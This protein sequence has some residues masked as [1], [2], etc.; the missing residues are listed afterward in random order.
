MDLKFVPF[1]LAFLVS[2][3][4]AS[5]PASAQSC[6]A[7]YFV[8]GGPGAY[9]CAPIPVSGSGSDGSDV[10][11]SVTNIR[12]PNG[13]FSHAV[14]VWHPDVANVWVDG[15]FVFNASSSDS[16]KEADR[17]KGTRALAECN[18]MMGSGCVVAWEWW[19]SEIVVF[20]HRD[21]TFSMSP[22]SDYQRAQ[23]ECS[24]TQVLEC[25]GFKVHASETRLLNDTAR[26]YYAVAAWVVG[27]VTDNNLYVATGH[28]SWGDANA[29]A[30]KACNDATS[31]KCEIATWNSS[32]Y[33]QA[34][35]MGNS[36]AHSFSFGAT[37]ETTAE[38]AKEAAQALC[39]EH[40]N[41]ICELQVTFDSKKPGLFVHDFNKAWPQ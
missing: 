18:K 16:D 20:H 34:Y 27:S 8:F 25:A 4:A 28:R 17:S 11:R 36:D 30:M 31:H 21:G 12:I 33:I 40:N 39:K 7:G 10:D 23:T 26:R 13:Y 37:A 14:M 5:S 2:L 1:A 22:M 19:D 32:G 38:R 35:R 9:G 41:A 3:I 15:G 24:A 6:P 29:A